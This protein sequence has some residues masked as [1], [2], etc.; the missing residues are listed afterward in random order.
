MIIEDEDFKEWA[1]RQGFPQTDWPNMFQA[2]QVRQPEIDALKAEAL[3][4]EVERLRL[5]PPHFKLAGWMYSSS[6]GVDLVRHRLSDAEKQLCPE[7][8]IEAPLWTETT[9]TPPEDEPIGYISEEDLA[10]IR[11]GADTAEMDIWSV[12]DNYSP[13][14]LYTRPAN[15]DLRKAARDLLDTCEETNPEIPV[16]LFVAIEALRGALD[17]DKP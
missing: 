10:D 2:W 11:L 6:R 15:D 1:T 3:K 14:P 8:T 7:D 5:G 16:L 9:P 17:K 12:K 13:V 4:A